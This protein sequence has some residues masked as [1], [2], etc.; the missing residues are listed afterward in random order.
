MK[1]YYFI[2]TVFNNDDN[3]EIK[4]EVDGMHEN[5]YAYPKIETIGGPM[6]LFE[7]DIDTKEI[8]I[9]QTIYFVNK[10][11]SLRSFGN[12]ENKKGERICWVYGSNDT[13]ISMP[14]DYNSSKYIVVEEHP[15]DYSKN[16]DK[17]HA[18]WIASQ[19]KQ[20]Q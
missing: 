6:C 12:R 13:L 14:V 20:P 9:L 7:E 11:E 8:K 3:Y 19:K 1:K 2:Y 17:R 10:E 15:Y 16:Y 4:L 18:D 5:I